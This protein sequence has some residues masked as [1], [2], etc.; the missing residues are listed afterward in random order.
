M[1]KKRSSHL[2]T[3]RPKGEVNRIVVTIAFFFLVI[4][5]LC[6][7]YAISFAPTNP[8]TWS[9]AAFFIVALILLLAYEDNSFP[10]IPKKKIK[11]A[12][13]TWFF[14]W[15]FVAYFISFMITMNLGHLV[16]MVLFGL[17]VF[18]GGSFI[19]MN[20]MRWSD[21]KTKIKSNTGGRVK[22]CRKG[23]T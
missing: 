22:T 13:I 2:V 5:T 12:V 4:F 18:F 6:S 16:M 7:V 1:V 9:M 17:V 3:S 21:F 11:F 10:D 15:I 20:D 14:T 8:A 19:F 23:P